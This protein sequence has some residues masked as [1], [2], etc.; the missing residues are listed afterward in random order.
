MN[1]NLRYGSYN[2][3]PYILPANRAINIDNEIDFYLADK[4]MKNNA[5]K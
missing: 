1:K 3:R 5:K 4:L 2:S